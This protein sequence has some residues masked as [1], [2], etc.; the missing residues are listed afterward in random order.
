MQSGKRAQTRSDAN[1]NG[2]QLFTSSPQNL[3][4]GPAW[5]PK[6]VNAE[7]ALGTIENKEHTDPMAVQR[8][9]CSISNIADIA[10]HVDQ[11]QQ[12]R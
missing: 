8:P 9:A 10:T 1:V 3:P 11:R 12:L 7:K 5:Q 6:F 2:L 4:K